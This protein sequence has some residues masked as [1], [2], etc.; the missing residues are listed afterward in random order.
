MGK[1]FRVGW[2]KAGQHL[3]EF[4]LPW[5]G[6]HNA[7]A[8][9]GEAGQ[10]DVRE[11]FGVGTPQ[12]NLFEIPLQLSDVGGAE[13]HLVLPGCQRVHEGLIVSWPETTGS[14]MDDVENHLCGAPI[15]HMGGDVGL[16]G[17]GPWPSTEVS[18]GGVQ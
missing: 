14:G 12:L 3:L 15:Q 9:Q 18:Q 17:T 8:V 4:R 2:S 5:D 11:P 7:V 1:G 6:H 16:D 10:A 13:H